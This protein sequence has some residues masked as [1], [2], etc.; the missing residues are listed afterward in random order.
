MMCVS[1][2]LRCVGFSL[3]PLAIVCML[4]NILLLFPELKY[5]FLLEGHVTRE[6]T[7][8]T[9][10]WGSGFLVLLGARS[11][12]LS[13]KTKGCCAFRTEMLCQLVYSCVCLFVAGFCCL[14]SA[15]GL[16]QGPLC[17]HNSESG[18]VWD[19]PLKPHADRD[20]GYLYNRTLW[21]GVCLE[22]KGVVL[23]NVVLFSVLGAASGMQ[24]LI[25]G[26]N[27][28]I[29]FLGIILG[30]GFCNNKISPA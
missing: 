8:A 23:W 10:L 17:L 26:A 29:S 3:V 24:T 19:V 7:W 2:S 13:S 18:P 11:F 21:S 15:T 5:N 30:K 1:S 6:A 27:I 12:V 28:L 20:A 25:C 22:P 9:G 16:V 4:S 14:V